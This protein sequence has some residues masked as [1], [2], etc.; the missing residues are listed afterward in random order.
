[1][2]FEISEISK[3]FKGLQILDLYQILIP[4]DYVSRKS[5]LCL[6]IDDGEK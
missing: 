1:M 4:S 2:I 6:E 3:E 5:Q